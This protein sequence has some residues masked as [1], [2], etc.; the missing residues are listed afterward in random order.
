[1]IVNTFDGQIFRFDTAA[2]KGTPVAVP[3][4]PNTPMTD[5]DAIKLPPKYGGKV[6]LIAEDSVG[7]VVL[8]SDDGWKTAKY[9]GLI[10]NNSTA[11]AGGA[12]TAALEIAGSVFILEEFFTD[13]AVAGTNGGNRTSF[14]LIDIT[15]KV[16]SLVGQ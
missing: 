5:G 9:L 3:R 7:I 13:P 10:P 12:S 11:A 16:A 2:D 14:P 4:T 15:S 8:K 6:A 1:M